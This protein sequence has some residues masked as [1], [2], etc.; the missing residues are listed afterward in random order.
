MSTIGDLNLEISEIKS[1]LEKIIAEGQHKNE[2]YNNS[3]LTISQL[4]ALIIEKD[5][6]INQLTLTLNSMGV[7]PETIASLNDVKILSQQADDLNMDLGI[8]LP[9]DTT[10]QVLNNPV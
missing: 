3:L 5:L 1:K 8:G 9:L 2:L 10:G 7:S 6:Q 4:N